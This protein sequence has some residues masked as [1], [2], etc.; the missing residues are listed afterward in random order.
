M[1]TKG[2]EYRMNTG[3]GRLWSLILILLSCSSVAT[4]AKISL[5]R[6][7]NPAFSK[8]RSRCKKFSIAPLSDK[9]CGMGKSQSVG[10]IQSSKAKF[11][12][13]VKGASRRPQEAMR[14]VYPHA[15]LERRT[16]RADTCADAECASK[17]QANGKDGN[18]KRA[19]RKR[20]K[21]DTNFSSSGEDHQKPQNNQ[22]Q[23][24]HDIYS[25][26]STS[27]AFQLK[28]PP[29]HQHVI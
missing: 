18:A 20:G 16:I 23:M 1:D 3:G 10:I 2:F 17:P 11:I 5:S 24:Q 13:G 28:I 27:K 19:H 25:M 8:T 4:S 21:G 22:Q 7:Q 15:E 14:L 29:C 9:L 12:H 26:Y 6:R